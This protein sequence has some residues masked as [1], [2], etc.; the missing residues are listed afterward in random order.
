MHHNIEDAPQYLKIPQQIK[1]HS[2]TN[3]VSPGLQPYLS[4]YKIYA[5][6]NLDLNKSLNMEIFY[7]NYSHVAKMEHNKPKMWLQRSSKL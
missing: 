4:E 5:E 7:Q 3:I 6:I 2:L 1:C